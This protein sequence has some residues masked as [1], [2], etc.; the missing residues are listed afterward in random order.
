MLTRRAV[1]AGGAGVVA[2]SCV[3]VQAAPPAPLGVKPAAGVAFKGIEGRIGGRVGV[4]ALDT[5][6]GVMIGHRQRER[7]AMAST[8]K[9]LLAAG[10]L[11]RAQHGM[12]L[13][14]YA[15]F[16][17]ADLVGHSP[18]CEAA[19][20]PETGIGKLTL[21]QLCEATVTVSDNCAANLLLVPMFG[22]EG[23]TRFIRESGDAITRLDRIELD[24]NENAPGDPRDT[25]TPE[26]MAQTAARLLSTDEVLRAPMR[27]MLTGWMRASTTGLDRLRAGLP[28]DWTAGD[29][30]GT[31]GNGAHNDVAIAFPPGRPPIVIASYFSESPAPNADKAAAHAEVA[32]IV[33]REFA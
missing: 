6:S 7:F 32:R 24:L 14:D 8:F 9:W 18:V 12:S 1:M 22:P 31:G 11:K 4:A 21:E 17:R 33:A 29:K 13:E 2:A 30:T 26:A 20:D 3:P 27:E 15:L 10:I 28:V 16:G 25:T 23:L 5:G 19:I